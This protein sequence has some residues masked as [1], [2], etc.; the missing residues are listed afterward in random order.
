[1]SDQEVLALYRRLEGANDHLRG[2]ERRIRH[3]EGENR[4]LREENRR[5]REHQRD[6]DLSSVID[7][8]RDVDKLT[9]HNTRLRQR[10]F[11]R[12]DDFETNQDN[13]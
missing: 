12:L 7:L 9:E 4:Q 10:L 6:W 2:A 1:M 11:G 8:R 5:L 3:L 13:G